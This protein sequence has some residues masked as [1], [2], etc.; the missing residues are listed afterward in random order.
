M[1]PAKTAGSLIDSWYKVGGLNSTFPHVRPKIS[2]LYETI[3]AEYAMAQ[4]Y[5]FK[6]IF[7]MTSI[8]REDIKSH[9]TLSVQTQKKVDR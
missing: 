8:F 9:W 6:P 1:L 5:F 4:I 2:H 3:P 7:K